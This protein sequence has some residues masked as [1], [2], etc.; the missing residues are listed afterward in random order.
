M[1]DSA[2]NNGLLKGVTVGYCAVGVVAQAMESFGEGSV[3]DLDPRLLVQHEQVDVV[4]E[5]RA[6]LLAHFVVAAAD[7]QQR[8]V[9]RQ[10]AHGVPDAAAGRHAAL[11]DALPL[12]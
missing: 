12:D 7:Y 1:S 11:A 2:K 9:G 8:L 3:L 4:E 6:Q 5:G 10:H